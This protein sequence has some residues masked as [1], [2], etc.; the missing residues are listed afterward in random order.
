[1]TSYG[2]ATHDCGEDAQL[3]EAL[4]H[5]GFV[6]VAIEANTR[7]LEAANNWTTG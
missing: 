7:I 2:D 4:A 6:V 1:M 3:P 5:R